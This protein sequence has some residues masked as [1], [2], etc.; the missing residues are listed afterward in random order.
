MFTTA[1]PGIGLRNKIHYDN[2]NTDFL[3]AAE[4]D[5]ATQREAWSNIRN[6]VIDFHRSNDERLIAPDY[7]LLVYLVLIGV[8]LATHV[9]R[10]S[11]VDAKTVIFTLVVMTLI[12]LML[13]SEAFRADVLS[14]REDVEKMFDLLIGD[15]DVQN[16]QDMSSYEELVT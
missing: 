8:V 16:M 14:L 10:P 11:L 2:T 6:A 1:T 12:F 5:V 15:V 9:V 7:T 3:N 13:R 4:N